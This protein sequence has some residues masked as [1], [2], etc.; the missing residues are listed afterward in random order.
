MSKQSN[1]RHLF[2]VDDEFAIASTLA[3][4]LR[5]QG[6]EVNSF[7][8]PLKALQAL[9]TSAPDLLI[10]DVVMPT[11]SGIEL[12]IKLREIHPG[13]KVI[14]FSGQLVTSQLLDAAKADGHVFEILAK[15]IHPTDLLTKIRS[16]LGLEA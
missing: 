12:G 5:A 1:S 11:F 4:I 7:T 14:L 2:V 16:V 9:Q 10:T 3:L 15:P 8:D 6:F 13:C